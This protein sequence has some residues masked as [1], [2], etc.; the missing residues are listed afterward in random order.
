M[1]SNLIT[2]T[3]VAGSIE[4]RSA[5]RS[6]LTANN[7]LTSGSAIIAEWNNVLQHAQENNRRRAV[8]RARASEDAIQEVEQDGP[9][10]A[11]KIPLS[12]LGLPTTDSLVTLE[13]N[14]HSSEVPEWEAVY[15]YWKKPKIY[16]EPVD[17]I[18]KLPTGFTLTNNF[19]EKDRATLLELW[20]PF[21]WNAA[22]IDAFIQTYRDN[23]ALWVSGVRDQNGQLASACMGEALVF[24][25]IYMVE[26]TEFGTRTDL[27]GKNLSTVAVVGLTAQIVQKALYEEG[28]TPLIMA[29]FNM[30]PNSRS[31]V[32]GRK[33]GFTIPGVEGVEGLTDPTQVL[34]KNVAVL[35]G[36]GPSD[37]L[38]SQLPDKDRYRD[39]FR[40]PYRYWRNFIVGMIPKDR[41]DTSYSKENTAQILNRFSSN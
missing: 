25:G 35:D 9:Q 2:S 6:Y 7:Q 27:R 38:F 33:V 36:G 26:A 28:H 14:I 17:E 8:L 13:H 39:A 41:I 31:D 32:V 37:L 12:E 24:D 5:G 4:S 23:N 20:H 34:R 15:D 11:V 21:G 1:A 3:G 40:D 30:H 19:S 22:K 18:N 10:F 29:E 16:P